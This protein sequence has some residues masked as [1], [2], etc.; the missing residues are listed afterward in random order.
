[1]KGWF[2]DPLLR[3]GTLLTLALTS[4]AIFGPLLLDVSALRANLELQLAGP[5]LAHPFG[6]DENGQ[7]LL[8]L[9]VGGARTALLVG[10]GTVGISAFF[11]VIVGSVAG[12]VGGLTDQVIMRLVDVVLSFPGILLALLVLFV[13]REPNL[14]SVV[15]ALSCAGWAGYARLVRGEVKSVSGREYVMAARAQGLTGFRVLTRHVL[16]NTLGPLLVQATF[17]MA[18]A[19]LAEAGLSFLGLGPQTSPSWGALLD[20]GARY[21]LLAPHLAI[22]PGLAIMTTVLGVNLLGDGLRDLLDPRTTTHRR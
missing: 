15:F 20:Q 5:S 1:M 10:L 13:T 19:I 2:A 7:D 18:A 17:G 16:P 14:W 11:G 22:F 8:T 3:A 12:Y 21:F 9:V 6:M 4:V